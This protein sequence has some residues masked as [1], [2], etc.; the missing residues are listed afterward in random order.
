LQTAGVCTNPQPASDL[1]DRSETVNALDADE[2]ERGAE[3][4]GEVNGNRSILLDGRLGWMGSFKVKRRAHRQE[5]DE[6][7]QDGVS[8]HGD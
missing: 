6:R 1:E 5:R 7:D 3:S 4:G 2:A 8:E